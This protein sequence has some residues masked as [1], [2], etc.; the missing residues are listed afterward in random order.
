MVADMKVDPRLEMFSIWG[1][2]ILFDG[3]VFPL[4][5][6]PERR[7]EVGEKKMRSGKSGSGIELSVT[8]HGKSEVGMGKGKGKGRGARGDGDGFDKYSELPS[9][10]AHSPWC[11]RDDDRAGSGERGKGYEFERYRELPSIV[12]HGAWCA[13]SGTGNDDGDVEDGGRKDGYRFERYSELPSVFA[14]RAWYARNEDGDDEEGEKE[15][16]D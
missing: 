1:R 16:E 7:V 14:H 2:P 11:A 4:P 5:R 13:R 15:D 8:R 3:Y 9:V 10:V 6:L 12:A